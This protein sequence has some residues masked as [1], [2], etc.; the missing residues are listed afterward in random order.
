VTPRI[1]GHQHFWKYRP[2]E[3][4]WI[5][6]GME[7]IRRDFLPGD[8]E[9]ELHA[10]GIDG[11][12]TVQARQN[13]VETTWLLDLSEQH[14]FLRGVVGWV[15]LTEPAIAQVI[16]NLASR[17]RL[18]GVRHILNDEP[19][20]DYMLRA[21]F[22]AGISLLRRFHLADDILIFERHLPQTLQFVDRHPNQVFVLD[23][24]G[25]PRIRERV[26]SPWRESITDLA[27][28]ENVYCKLSG[29]VTE[30]ARKSWTPEVRVSER[31]WLRGATAL[32]A[33]RLNGEK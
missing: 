13:L 30:A 17:T 16:E 11:A 1:D 7:A 12:V 6:D 9:A 8:L 32:E 25:K 33:Y 3:F 2:D 29:V 22:N 26:L 21:D 15:P 24:I 19:D 14:G 5:G 20:D 23:H 10:A 28:R 27:R 4:P 31:Q 18:K